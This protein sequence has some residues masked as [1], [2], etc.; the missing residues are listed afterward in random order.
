MLRVTQFIAMV[1]T[2]LSLVPL[3]AH[4]AELPNKINLA[5]SDY[6]IAHNVY[7][8]W[9]LFGVVMIGAVA[10]NLV[11]A[12]LL[13]GH[14]SA[15]GLVLV[16]LTCLV[17]TLTIFFSFTYPANQATDNWTAIP[18]DW[19]SL[20]LQWELSHAVNAVIAFAGFCALTWSLLL[21]RE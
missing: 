8:G 4:L 7:R 6:F 10:A 2:A 20:R 15:L 5:Q 16:N 19:Q 21:T 1:L 9:D 12:V 17:G 18:A 3:G 11:L 13:R 14:R